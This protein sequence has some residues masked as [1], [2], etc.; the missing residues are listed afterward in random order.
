MA[1]ATI[2]AG[3]TSAVI[4]AANWAA[5]GISTVWLV[6]IAWYPEAYPEAGFYRAFF[7]SA[8]K[9]DLRLTLH[10]LILVAT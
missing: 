10:A 9:V 1:T 2:F 6:D 8:C 3:V 4:S 7:G 5:S